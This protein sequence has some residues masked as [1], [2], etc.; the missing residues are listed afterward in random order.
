MKIRFQADNDLDQRIV[1]ATKRLDPTIDFQTAH[2]LKL[3]GVPDTL[4]LERTAEAKRILVSHDRRTLPEFFREF[5]STNSSPGL[6]IVAPRL[7]VGR[8]AELL[9]LLWAASEAEEYVNVIY[10][11]P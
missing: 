10:D 9:H 3:H 8:A 2:A 6:I 1:V 4:V 5:I 11:L 7:P